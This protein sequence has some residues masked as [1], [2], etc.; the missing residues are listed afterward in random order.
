M[1][2]SIEGEACGVVSQHTG[3]GF[4]VHTVLESKGNEGMPEVVKSDSFQSCP[5]QHSLE[6]VQDAVGRHGASGGRGEHMLATLNDGR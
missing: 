3:D 4:H 2:V 1:G 5:I 6:H